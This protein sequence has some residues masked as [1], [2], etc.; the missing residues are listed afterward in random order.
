MPL[1]ASLLALLILGFAA[2]ARDPAWHDRALLKEFCARYDAIGK[3]GSS[4]TRGAHEF[5]R[6]QPTVGACE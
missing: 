5:R 2:H 6:Q 4:P 3:T 1:I